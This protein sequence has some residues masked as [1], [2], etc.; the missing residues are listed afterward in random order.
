MIFRKFCHQLLEIV[1]L[2]W[3]RGLQQI[4]HQFEYR[5]NVS[6]FPGVLIR[7]RK[8]FR[9]QENDSGE[10]ALRCIVEECVLPI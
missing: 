5:N 2:S 3:P 10:Q 4:L 7:R 8:I 1:F 6:S 9:Q